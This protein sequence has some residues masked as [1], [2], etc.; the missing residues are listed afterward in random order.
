[1]ATEVS[2]LR[3]PSGQQYQ[4][5]EVRSRRYAG[6]SCRAPQCSL[7]KQRKSLEVSGCRSRSTHERDATPP[8]GI[9]TY[10]L[11]GMRPT[12]ARSPVT[13][14]VVPHRTQMLESPGTASVARIEAPANPIPFIDAFQ[15]L[16]EGRT[17]VASITAPTHRLPVTSAYQCQPSTAKTEEMK[18]RKTPSVTRSVG[19][20]R[21]EL[22]E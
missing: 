14:K 20:A 2:G 12:K 5:S 19:R 13:V 1:M 7:S 11:P 6:R 21:T 22:G 9:P 4:S 18:F 16:R 3:V 8:H 17:I 10:A 15:P